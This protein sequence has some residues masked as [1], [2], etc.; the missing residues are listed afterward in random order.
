MFMAIPILWI[1]SLLVTADNG[2]A[3]SIN[4]SSKETL[5]VPTSRDEKYKAKA[6]IDMFVQR[7]AKAIAVGVSL[8][9]TMNFTDFSSIRWL[10]LVS[11]VIT[12]IWII[13]VRYAGKKFQQ[14]TSNHSL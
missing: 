4:Q 14:M 3:Y 1:G 5:Y 7:F 11:I 2:F 6:F 10:S 13:A 9:I 12:V 8:V